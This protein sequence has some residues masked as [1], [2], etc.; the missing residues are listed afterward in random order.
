VLRGAVQG[1]GA[2]ALGLP[3]LE[4]MLPPRAR[5][6]ELTLGPIFG[7]FF[8]ANGLPWHDGH[9]SVQA[10]HPDA[11]TPASTGTGWAPT[12][13]LAPL[14]AHQPTVLTGLEPKTEIPSS[15]DGQSDGHM[16]GF[17]VG[18]TSDRPRPEGFDHPTHTLT[19]LRGTLDQVVAKDPRFYAGF[20]SPYRSLEIGTSTARFHDYGHWNAISYN[21]P[22]SLNPPISDPGRLYDLIFGVST[23]DASQ[24]RRALLLDSVLA[25]AADLRARLGAADRA[26]VEGHMEHLYEVQRRLSLD[27]LTCTSPGAPGSSADL[28]TQ[29]GIQADLLAAGLACNI[30]R[31]FSFMLTSPATTHVFSE[32]GVYQ[33]MHTVC[34]AG[35]WDAVYAITALQMRCF[36]RF[37]DAL[38]ARVDPLGASLLD[39]ALVY[40]TS[41]YGEGFQHGNAET[42]VVM[43]G[44]AAGRLRRGVHVRAPGGNLAS[45]HL[46]L[47][48][49]LGLDTP[50]FGFSGSETTTAFSEVLR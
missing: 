25:D 39:R 18:L 44:G 30:T 3:L 10:G 14:A 33:D 46:T 17:M 23:G 20:P 31:A 13:L 43:V 45:A 2:V 47:L 49:A 29:T 1:A 48:R 35:D 28:F 32:V 4:A 16:R 19:A 37:C 41:E 42:P 9:G 11:W 26:R 12:P 15:P 40:G 24:G 34:H 27:D 7:V 5:A 50:Q 21:G 6:E 8:W 36:A 22:D 38:A